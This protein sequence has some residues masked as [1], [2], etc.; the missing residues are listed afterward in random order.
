MGTK[1]ESFKDYIQA[2]I[3]YYYYS[4]IS[5]ER[6]VEWLIDNEHEWQNHYKSLSK[7]DVQSLKEQARRDIKL[8]RF[9]EKYFFDINWIISDILYN[10]KEKHAAIQWITDH[11]KELTKYQTDVD[12]ESFWRYRES[13]RSNKELRQYLH[14]FFF[15]PSWVIYDLVYGNNSEKE[16]AIAWLKSNEKIWKSSID[17]LDLHEFVVDAHNDPIAA[18]FFKYA[19]PLLTNYSKLFTNICK[20]S[21][22]NI[23]L[24]HDSIFLI[25]P[26]LSNKNNAWIELIVNLVPILN[27]CSWNGK[28]Y[29][30]PSSV[31]LKEQE[32]WILS[33]ITTIFD[34]LEDKIEGFDAFFALNKMTS[35]N[36]RYNAIYFACKIFNQI[37]EN[38]RY[39]AWQIITNFIKTDGPFI[40]IKYKVVTS[41]DS[42]FSLI[43]DADK[44][45]AWEDIEE[46]LILQDNVIVAKLIECIGN[47]FTLIP[48]ERVIPI[49]EMLHT[50]ADDKNPEIRGCAAESLGKF[51]CNIPAKYQ[52]QTLNDLNKLMDDSDNVV[53]ASAKYSMGTINIFIAT[54]S[55]TFEQF[56]EHLDLAIKYF[57]SSLGSAEFFNQAR[58]CYPLYKAYWNLAFT[59]I[60]EISDI[61]QYLFDA[62]SAQGESETRKNLV[63]VIKLL[64]NAVKEA[65][66]QKDFQSLKSNLDSYR[67][68]CDSAVF[69]LKNTEATAPMATKIF[70]KGL[71]IIDKRIK[72]IISELQEEAKIFCKKTKGT[73]QESLGKD[74]HVL[75]Q[76][77]S[78]SDELHLPVGLNEIIDN[79]EEK[80][81]GHL[82][83]K[84]KQDICLLIQHAKSETDPIQKAK[85][86]ISIISAIGEKLLTT[87]D[88]FMS[89][90]TKNIAKIASVQLDYQLT[91]TFPPSL[92]NEIPTKEK[93]LKCLRYAKQEYIDLILFPELCVKKSWIADIKNQFPEIV[94]IFG[95][96]YEG[97]ENITSVLYNSE[98][99]ATQKKIT[100]SD[101]EDPQITRLGMKSG[102]KTIHTFQTHFGDFSILICRDFGAYHNDL[103]GKSSLILVPSYNPSIERFYE[104]AH[105]HVTDSPSYIIFSNAAK[106]GGTSIFGQ[107]KKSY[108]LS[109]IQ[110]GYKDQND[111]SYN[112]CSIPKNQEGMI[113]VELDMVYKSP[114]V[115][116]PMVSSEENKN[117]KYIEIV[118]I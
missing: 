114:Q 90:K 107:L 60:N 104:N 55:E 21:E 102:P 24:A 73:I 57:E 26:L 117:I 92:I 99:V 27:G 7:A 63:K 75:A 46:L 25:F 13:L 40:E 9:L 94:I 20:I 41:L 15:H 61:E 38:Q 76:N 105:V 54:Q 10:N 97:N 67:K 34:Q 1:T 19:L 78:L 89:E 11:Q 93:I 91:L 49:S 98:I 115:P 31:V 5:Q 62:R 72:K 32:T 112:L 45:K 109:L 86:I 44:N 88:L 83:R 37:P 95:S 56:Q 71:P 66:R 53:S 36:A 12:R 85:R 2:I 77:L 110:K 69:F 29:R 35:S 118:K 87:S 101:F 59:D 23:N 96:Y 18:S 106:F 108:F 51:Y 39:E 6:H 113:I 52:D 84:E 17:F 3:H 81:C 111:S 50:L 58:F 116:S 70:S 14:V 100:P 47:A 80:I 68:F 103:K 33:I 16:S 28:Y 48:D 79:L 64:T 8:R 30:R 42:I 4:R 82:T 22:E 43:P 74:T 65:Q